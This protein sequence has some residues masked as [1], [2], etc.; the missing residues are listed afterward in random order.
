MRG[1]LPF[2]NRRNPTTISRLVFLTYPQGW[3]YW[4][5]RPKAGAFASEIASLG[6]VP[7][8]RS[9]WVVAESAF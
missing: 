7:E 9:S 8:A 6:E 4:A 2:C 3:Y 1:I 5:V